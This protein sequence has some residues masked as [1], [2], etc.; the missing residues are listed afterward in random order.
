MAAVPVVHPQTIHQVR[1]C[2][3]NLGKLGPQ[4]TS[5]SWCRERKTVQSSGITFAH[6]QRH[7]TA[8]HA[9]PQAPGCRQAECGHRPLGSQALVHGGSQG[10]QPE[11]R[12]ALEGWQAL[13]AQ[14]AVAEVMC[15]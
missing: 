4:Y 2:D 5:C 13:Q 9:L 12:A 8:A 15:S 3:A 10:A 6:L 11:Q 14:A 7:S 1:P